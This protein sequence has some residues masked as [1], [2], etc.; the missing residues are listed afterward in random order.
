LE[1]ALDAGIRHVC[2]DL[3]VC[4]IQPG[5]GTRCVASQLPVLDLAGGRRLR[6]ALAFPAVSEEGVGEDAVQPG[7][8]IR[9][10]LEL[11]E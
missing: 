3:G 2:Q 6:L 11:L 4:G 8:Q 1:C 10:G 9:A 7:L 5:G